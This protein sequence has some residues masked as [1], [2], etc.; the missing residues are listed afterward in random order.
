MGFEVDTRVFE[1]ALK[2]IL[3][4]TTREIPVVLN[5]TLIEIITTAAKL[6]KKASPSEIERKLTTATVSVNV[7]KTGKTLK[8]ARVYFKPT[9]MVY[10]IINAK[11]TREGKPGLNQAQMS[12][13][14][15]S[16]IRRRKAAVGY[17]A[18]A[19]WQK[20]LIALGGRGFGGASAKLGGSVQGGSGSKANVSKYFA[21][22][23]NTASAIELIGGNAALQEAF[24]SKT[25]KMIARL[26]EKLGKAAAEF[27]RRG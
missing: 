15:Q 22:A 5:S 9:M 12:L 2:G 26:E 1:Q 16:F 17:T 3:A 6:T 13:A 10:K 24:D 20:A 7:S 4:N 27:N 14:A 25:E 18:Y 8:K 19:G 11:Q 21:E 23:I